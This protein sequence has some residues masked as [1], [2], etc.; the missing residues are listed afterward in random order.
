MPREVFHIVR[1]DEGVP[2][3]QNDRRIQGQDSLYLS[4]RFVPI[5]EDAIWIDKRA[6]HIPE[7]D[8]YVV[9]WPGVG[10]CICLPG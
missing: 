6:S 4:S 1:L 8:G 2:P 7:A 9:C 10:F 3:S 5:Q